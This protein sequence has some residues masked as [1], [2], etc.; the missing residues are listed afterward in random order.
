MFQ[1]ISR[2]ALKAKR[3]LDAGCEMGHAPSC[4]NLAVM[5]KRGDDGI[6]KDEALFAKYSG[7]TN[8]LVKAAGA[9]RGVKAA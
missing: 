1:G 2:D 7:M 8:E 6:P 9:T 4:H 3:F 5:Y